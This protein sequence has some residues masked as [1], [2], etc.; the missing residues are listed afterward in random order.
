VIKLSSAC[1]IAKERDDCSSSYPKA[2][3]RV[4]EQMSL[5]VECTNVMS[6]N[7]KYI[8]S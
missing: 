2:D 7:T 6:M 4:N 3:A 5:S 8:R 1:C